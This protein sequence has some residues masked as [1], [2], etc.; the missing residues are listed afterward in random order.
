MSNQHYLK[1]TSP[2]TTG[3]SCPICLKLERTKIILRYAR[4]ILRERVPG[5][6]DS[7]ELSSLRLWVL[8]GMKKSREDIFNHISN[9]KS[10]EK[11]KTTEINAKTDRVMSVIE[12]GLPM[13]HMNRVIALEKMARKISQSHP[14]C[15]QCEA[16]LNAKNDNLH[17]HLEKA[18]YTDRGVLCG[19]CKGKRIRLGD[20]YLDCERPLER[21]T[22]YQAYNAGLSQLDRA[23]F[24]QHDGMDIDDRLFDTLDM[25]PHTDPVRIPRRTS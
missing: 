11:S 24:H 7:A 1:I 13:G 16:L 10:T 8:T 5:G 20:A 3:P 6:L 2:E 18:H 15:K 19:H 9:M 14:V 25:G 21:Q 4:K 23:R 12:K 22:L 17:R